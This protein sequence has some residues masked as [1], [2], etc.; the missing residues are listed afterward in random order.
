[1]SEDFSK[2]REKESYITE[3]RIPDKYIESLTALVSVLN[4]KTNKA[5]DFSKVDDTQTRNK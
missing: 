1:L 4:L 3:L 5:E 2:K